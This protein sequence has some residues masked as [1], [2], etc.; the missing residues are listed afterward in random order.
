MFYVPAEGDHGLPHDP[1]KAI[2]AP[3]PIGWIST[4]DAQGRPNLAPYSF[5]NAISA[6]P[7]IVMFSSTGRKHSVSNIEA[8]GEFVCNLATWDFRE[9][10]NETSA[11]LAEGDNEFDFAGL[12]PL[13]SRLVAPPRVEG[14]A[15][16]M[17]CRLIKTDPIAGLDGKPSGSTVVYG[18]VV[19]IHIDE[20]FIRDGLFDMTAA[21]TI[22][23]CGYMD[24]AVVDE[25]FRMKRPSGRG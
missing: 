7:H 4:L 5:F 1:F 3:R 10:M 12:S 8:T 15:A 20:R 9:A 18:E 14:A 11:T 16:A 19:G 2:V 6:N 22:A 17:E 25:L 23:R 13:P 21:R 24:Y